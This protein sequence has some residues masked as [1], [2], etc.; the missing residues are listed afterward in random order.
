M[1]TRPNPTIHRKK[2]FGGRATAEEMHAKYAFPPDAKCGGCGKRGGLQTR[3]IIL[4]PVD[5]VKRRDPYFNLISEVNPQEFLRMIMPTRYGPMIR[6][7]TSYAC[8]MCTP[9]LERAMAKAPDYC[10]VDIHRGVGKDK[11]VV[12]PNG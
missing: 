2:L 8:P 5:E 6:I 9:A 7:S 11:I 4:A 12:G 10:I 3:C 1:S